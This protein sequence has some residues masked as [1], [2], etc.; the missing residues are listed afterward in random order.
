LQKY[1]LL[2]SSF[3]F[4]GSALGPIHLFEKKI[5]DGWCPNKIFGYCYVC[6]GCVID[7]IWSMPKVCII[8]QK[9][10]VRQLQDV[11]GHHQTNL[12]GQ[13]GNWGKKE[14]DGIGC[15]KDPFLIYH[16]PQKTHLYRVM[17]LGLSFVVI[18]GLLLYLTLWCENLH[19]LSQEMGSINYH[20]IYIYIY[21]RQFGNC[22]E[23]LF[24]LWLW[25]GLSPSNFAWIRVAKVRVW[26]LN[27]NELG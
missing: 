3:F 9:I 4:L 16:P 21:R 20:I 2:F 18:F 10:C 24:A 11:F 22:D 23:S 6:F 8:R 25:L 19:P 7:T 5:K 26:N 1:H 15:N 14:A 12:V 17:T 27:H 13:V